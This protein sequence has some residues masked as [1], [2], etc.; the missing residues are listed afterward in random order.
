M[1][2]VRTLRTTSSPWRMRP[3][4]V[5]S[6]VRS[7]PRSCSVALIDLT[8]VLRAAVPP[9]ASSV[10]LATSIATQTAQCPRDIRPPYRLVLV[11]RWR[12]RVGQERTLRRRPQRR[13]DCSV[14]ERTDI[15][16]D[17]PKGRT[18]RPFGLSTGV[19]KGSCAFRDG[20][21][22][23]RCGCS[24]VRAHPPMLR[25]RSSTW[26]FCSFER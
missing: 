12:T 3:S 24:V 5:E 18:G 23:G 13:V 21:A 1:V 26:R 11:D 14:R 16:S 20:L 9:C 10:A 22:N 17:E 19:R 6:Q 15:L 7:A 8:V 2:S 25:W 4:T